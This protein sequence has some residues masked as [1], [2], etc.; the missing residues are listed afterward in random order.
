MPNET[1]E[2]TAGNPDVIS[3]H[4]AI[5]L[6]FLASME[7]QKAG[8]DVKEP[9]NNITISR[10]WNKTVTNAK[11][12]STDDIDALINQAIKTLDEEDFIRV[13]ALESLPKNI[14]EL[15]EANNLFNWAKEHKTEI[16]KACEKTRRQFNLF[17]LLGQE[18]KARSTDEQSVLDI[19]MQGIDENNKVI[20]GSLFDDALKAAMEQLEKTLEKEAKKLPPPTIKVADLPPSLLMLNNKITNSY[21]DLQDIFLDIQADGQIAM[22]FNDLPE[23]YKQEIIVRNERNYGKVVK[24]QVSSFVSLQYFGDLNGKLARIKG[25]DQSVMN[26]VCSLVAAGN[27]VFMLE[28]IWYLLTQKNRQK[29]KP[30]KRQLDRIMLSLHKY[31]GTKIEID[32]TNEINANLLT[33]DGE[34]IKPVI[35]ENLLYFRE[36]IRRTEKGKDVVAIQMIK[37]PIL[38][39]YSMAKANPQIVTIPVDWLKLESN[40]NATEDTIAIRDYLLKEIRQMQ[41]KNRDNPVINYESLLRTIGVKMDE[42]DRKKKGDYTRTVCNLLDAFKEKGII[43]AYRQRNKQKNKVVGFEIIL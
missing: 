18:L 14:D 23:D 26:A 30:T 25:Y 13:E 10:L 37:T 6:L 16:I 1:K 3:S 24:K 20:Q 19:Q 22:K 43:T 31:E 42:I 8:E 38:W 28:D 21:Y 7:K 5:F 9:F 40:T 35:R 29:N 11:P 2:A 36:L 34:R 27:A 15:Q 32:V 17:W 4:A 41:T 33:A 12:K 39:E